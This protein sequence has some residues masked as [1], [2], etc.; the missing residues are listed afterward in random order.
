MRKVGIIIVVALI[1]AAAATAGRAQAGIWPA[2]CHSMRCV[3]AHL[4]NLN[5]R[6]KAVAFEVF[7]CEQ[8]IPITQYEDFELAGDG[9]PDGDPITGLDVTADGDTVGAWFVIDGCETA[10]TPRSLPR[11]TNLTPRRVGD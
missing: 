6:V 2:H 9:Q 4:N 8:I 7:Q 11:G 5:R 3:N 1:L 10:T